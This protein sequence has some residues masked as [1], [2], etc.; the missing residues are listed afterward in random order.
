MT[1][2]P[3]MNNRIGGFKVVGK[4]HRREWNGITADLNEVECA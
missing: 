4:I 3:R 1:F 2:Q